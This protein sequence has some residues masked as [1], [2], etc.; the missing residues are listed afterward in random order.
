MKQKETVLVVVE[1]LQELTLSS[2]RNLQCIFWETENGSPG[3]SRV[4]R[5]GI[6]ENIPYAIQNLRLWKPRK[7]RNPESQDLIGIQ[8]LCPMTKTEIQYLESGIHG[9]ESRI[10]AVSDS[11]IWGNGKSRFSSGSEKENMN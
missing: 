11:L 8:I 10:Q 1:G 5:K 6:R 2:S 3:K 4:P 7:S 9:V